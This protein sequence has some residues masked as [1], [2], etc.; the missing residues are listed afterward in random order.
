VAWSS[1]KQTSTA[2]SSTEAEYISLT[3][4][5]KQAIWIRNLLDSLNRWP[6]HQDQLLPLTLCCDNQGAIKLALNPEFHARTKHID[7]AHHFIREC[8]RNGQITLKWVPTK[9]MCADDMTKAL[10]RPAR[11]TIH[12]LIGLLPLL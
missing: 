8:V 3:H 10:A 7:I 9:D 2:L 4:A 11:L 1:K 6:S 5:S 12:G